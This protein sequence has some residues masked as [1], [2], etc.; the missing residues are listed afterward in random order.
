MRII[1]DVDSIL[2]DLVGYFCEKIREK[3]KQEVYPEN[4]ENYDMTPWLEPGSWIKFLYPGIFL[5]MEPLANSKKVLKKISR[6][7]EIIIVSDT[8]PFFQKEKGK[9]LKKHFP[10]IKNIIWTGKKHT[11]E[12]DIIID[13]NP[14]HLQTHKGIK[15]ALEYGYNKNIP[16]VH[17]AK[18]WKEIE[19][20]LE[21]IFLDA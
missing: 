13:D 15:I 7:H 6:D 19:K 2:N 5:E 11:V 12:A 9:W 14:I 21:G 17:Y 1:V 10:F 16:N 3:T 18:N 4:L 20:I 8:S